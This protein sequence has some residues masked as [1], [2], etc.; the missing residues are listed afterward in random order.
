[1][2]RYL[3][4]TLGLVACGGNYS[5]SDIEFINAL[6]V[7]QELE[8]KLPQSAQQSA[9]GD[10]GQIGQA[11]QLGDL[12]PLYAGTKGASDAFNGGLFWLLSLIDAIREVTPTQREPDRRIWGPYPD[13]NHPGFVFR[14]VMARESTTTYSYEIDFQRSAGGSGWFPFVQGEFLASGGARK[15]SGHVQLLVDTARQNGLLNP[16]D[17]K[18]VST[19]TATYVT[20]R[21]PIE[22]GMGFFGVPSSSFL[23]AAYDYKE[24]VGGQ[25][26]IAFVLVVDFGLGP[27]TLAIISRWLP[28]GRGRAD[29][30]VLVG[31]IVGATQVECWDT[32]F[33]VVYS[34]KSWEAPSLTVGSESNC[35]TLAPF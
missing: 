33:R 11:L 31:I 2:Y 29:A 27:T 25:G 21:S 12:S 26:G 28:D 35:P 18:D 15:G 32:Q 6:P 9:L 5:N 1:M 23:G 20:D 30:V 34:T 24:S 14:V 22:V 16:D 8:S 13:N 19:L 3:W 4:M 7:R 10:V 17:L